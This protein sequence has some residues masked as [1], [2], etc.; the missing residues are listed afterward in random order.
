MRYYFAKFYD[1]KN[2]TE[3][4]VYWIAPGTERIALQICRSGKGTGI[5]PSESP[6]AITLR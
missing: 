4:T 2:P 1:G 5:A 6:S 3:K